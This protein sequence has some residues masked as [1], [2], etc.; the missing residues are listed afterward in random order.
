L[1]SSGMTLRTATLP[2]HVFTPETRASDI[3][4]QTCHCP[5]NAED[6]V[7]WRAQCLK[8]DGRWLIP[9]YDNPAQRIMVW[10]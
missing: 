1:D 7:S 5:E 2:E 9:F 8:L 6:H 10:S 4:H 3:G